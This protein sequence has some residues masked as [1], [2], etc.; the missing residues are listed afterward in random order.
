MEEKKLSR[1]ELEIVSVVGSKRLRKRKFLSLVNE[2]ILP[3][4]CKHPRLKTGRALALYTGKQQS[5][6]MFRYLL[7]TYFFPSLRQAQCYV[8]APLRV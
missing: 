4:A 5:R 8:P 3:V 2:Y 1:V 6:Q 7:N